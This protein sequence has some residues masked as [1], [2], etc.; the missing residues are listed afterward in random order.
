M[1]AH[2]LVVVCSIV[3]VVLAGL[4]AVAAG[5]VPA[6][7]PP[8]PWQSLPAPPGG[9]VLAL[10]ASPAFSTDHILFA[11][12][13]TGLSHSSDAGQ[14]WVTLGPGP[15]GPISGT[16]KI[17][18]SPAYPADNTLFVLTTTAELPGRRVLRSTNG[19]ASW[20]TVWESSAVQ[21]LVVSP[22]Y[23]SDH[24]LFLGGAPFGQPQV[25]R[26]TNGGSTWLPTAGQPAD[27]D[28][29]FLALSPAYVSDHTLFAAGFG[30]M[31]RSTNGGLTWQRLNAPSP[32]RG[33]AISPHY[34]TDHTLW[35]AYRE[36]E[37]S[38]VQPESGITRSTDGGTTWQV[39]TAGLPGYYVTSYHDLVIDPAGEALYVAL[40]DSFM[41][42]EYPPRVYRSDNDG[43]R[44][45]SQPLLPSG[46]AP[47]RLLAAAPLPFLYATSGGGTAYIYGSTC[48]QALADG[49]FETDPNLNYA[50]IARAW[51]IPAT[52]YPAAY[53]NNPSLAGAWAMRSGIEAGG[54]N[55]LSYSDF[56]QRISIPADA[57]RAT[58][59]FG[60]YPVLGDPAAIG[61]TRAP[62][63][64]W[65]VDD[66][67]V[68]DYQYVL[69]K[70]DDGT[71]Q[72]LATWRANDRAWLTTEIDLLALRGRSF[73][74]QFGT[75][76]NGT[77]GTSAMFVDEAAV[78]ICRP[79]I[80]PSN[81][82][83]RYLPLVLHSYP[84]P[85]TATPT[86]TRTVT[87]TPTP[88]H[89][90]TPT[91]T[92]TGSGFP[93]I[94]RE[95]IAAPGAPGP[96]YALTNSQLLLVSYDRGAH[97]QDAPQGVPPAVGR[98]G[99][100]I[101]YANPST[102]YLGTFGGLFRTNSAGGAS[103]NPAG[104]W[105]LLH[106]VRTHA[107]S[108]E[109]G[110]PTTLWAAPNQ[111][112]DF[113][114]GVFVIKSDDG[115]QIW[116]A[117]SGGLQGW[118]V[119]NPIII[120]P[121]DPNTLY[122][123]SVSKYGGGSV[124]RGVSSGEWRWLP[125]PA[126]SYWI[127][128][129]LAFDNAGNALYIGGRS[130]GILWRSLNANTPNPG[131][132][133]WEVVHDFGP[134]QA[135]QPLAVGWGPN[136]PAIYVNLTETN[137]WQTRLLRSDDGGHT[138]VELTLPPGPPPPPS[139]QYQLIV[140]GYPA[141]RQIAD[142]R[143]LP[144]Y[145]FTAAG[146]NH[147]VNA[148]DWVL[149]T[150]A[151]PRPD[152]VY[153]PAN[154]DLIWTGL[155]PAC[156]VG[157]PPEPMY[158]STD[159][160]R[161]WHEL[162]AGRDL[163]PVVAHPTDPNRVYAFGCDGPYLTSDS[164]T[165]WQH[166][167]SPLWG[168]YFVSDVAPVDPNWTT[169]FAAGVSEGGG[170]MVARSTNG[171]QTWQ[172][173]TPLYADIWWITDVW[174][175]PTNPQ[176][177]YFTEPN[178][179]WRSLDG[180]NTWQRFTA[181]LED[182]IWAP[183]RET[184]GLLEI[185]NRLDEP[186]HLFLGT[187]AGLYESHDLG[188]TWHKLAGYTW[189]TQPVDGL[190]AEGFGTWL[191]SPDGAF[192][193]FT[194]YTTPTPTPTATPPSGPTPTPTLPP[195]CWEGLTNGG[196]ETNA[197]WVIKS[198]PVLAAY[199]TSPVHGGSRSMR[200]GI[201]A[202]GANVASYSPVEQ[203]IG[204]PGYWSGTLR[205]WHYNV[206]GDGGAG[207]QAPP[208]DPAELPRNVAELALGVPR[209]PLATDFFYVIGIWPNG[210]ITWLWTERSNG[211]AWRQAV[212]DLTP[213]AGAPVRL[214]FGTYNNGTGGISRT[215]IDD[216]SLANCPLPPTMTPTPTNTYTPRPP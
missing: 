191:N 83:A 189:D 101:D 70:F 148:T 127:N 135:V 142:Y 23:T 53:T 201:P 77:G 51:E 118:S 22:A 9:T 106:T 87:A 95:L 36:M 207:V 202:G 56:R 31:H 120:D 180:G 112:H 156:L 44:W 190:L 72:M 110:Q 18:P 175:D 149:T 136:G 132:V 197:G 37:G 48:Y 21:D 29:Y 177:V 162:P 215:F 124:Y 98:N 109:Y 78:W 209:I 43:Q 179:V 88:T 168:L 38:G 185:V 119:A 42:S 150:N 24:T 81:L 30:P 102:L 141:T 137:G 7:P 94:V 152:F 194:G 99:L 105:Q 125:M 100:G 90:P 114:S 122:I 188:E 45:A 39:T 64:G 89:T 54:P 14:H 151:S 214:Q 86:P 206:W 123:M 68:A 169:V 13:P 165:T 35:A 157:E 34:A 204:V 15:T 57:T 147:K 76:N 134:N 49:G 115:G 107:L 67:A 182:I 211:Q 97:W 60:R 174:V 216:A 3:F 5:Q 79:Q 195:A 69:A 111:G 66:P 1:A 62:A 145:A 2:R 159:A 71:Y 139:N 75:Y 170:G 210:D 10:A 59:T 50:G 167:D 74:L 84:A 33:L 80:P 143:V 161:T 154:S 138:W 12:T 6:D 160:G 153:S 129:G 17:V 163:Q 212:L 27:L 196:F 140:N 181:G 130:P 164:G 208:P 4:A 187:Q 85:A 61:D 200:T 93:A 131:D 171:G 96:L 63:A 92:P 172:Q 91:P 25:Y 176:R 40:D 19:G 133:T 192:Y 183:G 104:Q 65:L 166:Q 52:T 198:N 178:G 28:V 108:V 32:T 173:V 213:F 158:H 26:S 55:V 184:Y 47:Q 121:D 41:A 8:T 16:L 20:Q 146:L 113:G 73:R 58:L 103:T 117:A 82:P 199:V 186:Q 128:T 205:F 126:A 203:A 155:T 116:R 11:G 144:R 46:A 193:L